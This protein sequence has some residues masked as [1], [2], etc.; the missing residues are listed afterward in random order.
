MTGKNKNKLLLV[1]VAVLAV[2]CVLY[3]AV[4]HLVTS[5]EAKKESEAA[6]EEEASRIRINQMEDVAQV[7]VDST[8][9][10]LTFVKE[11]DTWY[12]D[13][14]RDFPV[15][16]TELANIESAAG[17]LEAVRAIEEADALEDYGLDAPIAEITVVDASG[18]SVEMY[19]GDA[20]NSEYYLKT[21]DADTVYTV[22]SSFVSQIQDKVLYDFVQVENLPITSAEK[23]QTMEIE[24]DGA[25]HTIER[26]VVE[27][28]ET[29]E[30]TEAE[31]EV[32]E[33]TWLYFIDDKQQIKDPDANDTLG[34]NLAQALVGMRIEDCVDYNGT[35]DELADF[36][37]E[38]PAMRITY[39]FLDDE[40][41]LQSV[42]LYVGNTSEDA[43]FYYVVSSDS[44]AINTISADSIDGILG[45][46][47]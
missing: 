9:G 42:T 13:A 27:N 36:G 34:L 41:V 20:T 25:V 35:E 32:E 5:S 14:D 11:A 44:K 38:N 1:L 15:N 6:A 18:N 29:E 31:T 47:E 21:A 7:T 46:F 3:F 39:T 24:F 37:L 30:E 10:A 4:G 12:Y 45:Y 16:Q 40:E 17:A 2:V 23:I 33:P 19:V 43:T 26:N 8:E 22:S 28:E